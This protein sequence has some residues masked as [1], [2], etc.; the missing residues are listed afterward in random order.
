MA[1]LTFQYPAWYF[2]F[3][4][5]LG[6]AYALVL[7]FRDKTFHDQ[8]ERLNWI[9]GIFRFTTVTILSMLLLSPLLKSI[10]TDTQ[11]PVIVLAQDQSESVAAGMNEEQRNNYRRAF[12]NL[13]QRLGNQYDVKQYAFG[14]E[15]RENIDFQYTDKV[16]NLSEVLTNVYDLYS[17]QNLGAIVLATDGIYNE[18]SN[19]VYLNT[20]LT[21]PIYTIALGDTTI[22]KDIVLKRVFHNKIAYLGDKFT[23]QVDVS[24]QNFTGSNTSLSIY[25][26]EG[27]N[28]RKIQQVPI[29][30]D[31][32]DYFTT[33][34]IILDASQAGVQRYRIVVESLSG[35]AT[36]INNAKEIF[37]DVL[38]ARQKIL[39]LANSPHPDI[40]AIRQSIE[41]NKNY[42]V[43][44]A[45]INSLTANVGIYDFVVLHQLPS[46]NNDAANVFNILQSKNIPH[47]FIAGMQTNFARLNQLQNLVSFQIGGSSTNDVQ[48]KVATGFNNFTISDQ[49]VNELPQFPPLTAPFGE[50]QVSPGAAVLLYQRIGKVETRYPLLVLGEEGDAKV[51]ILCAE[52]IWKWRLF[53]FLQNQNHELFNELL[54]KPVQF[55]SLKE[56]KRKFRVTPSKNIFNENEAVFFDAE[57][58]NDNYELI[59]EPDASI[60]ITNAEGKEFDFTFNKTGRAYSLNAGI[61]PVGNYTYRAAVNYNG[62][63][64]TASGQFSVQPVQVELFE[65]TANHNL[66][67][68]LSDKYGGAVV[69]PNNIASIV[70]MIEQKGTVKPVIYET[71]KTRPVINLKWI[72]F[73]LLLLLTGEWFMRRYFGA[74]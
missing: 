74:Y 21:A 66:L 26:V 47:L 17:N 2:I 22:K 1:N 15:V 34:E 7:Y 44:L 52:G 33:R 63:N 25:K 57:L 71:A 29:N 54:G 6:A 14:N 11:K 16:T 53:D 32:N 39:I 64:L 59:N 49:L 35:E 36:N 65:T 48:G 50:F 27:G 12:E 8:S 73:L 40:T 30:I 13:A 38:D 61:F 51:G 37:I 56:D 10:I 70:D 46:K 55:L 9:M 24:A 3:C 42:Q 20:K 19:P 58:Y 18:G 60:S 68:L 5:L 28:N 62:Q 23:V 31:R 41:Q 69:Y 72:F 4:V 67:R 45:F 43:D